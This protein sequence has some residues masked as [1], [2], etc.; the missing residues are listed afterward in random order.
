MLGADAPD[1]D[2]I[3]GTI[4]EP[5][6]GHKMAGRPYLTDNAGTMHDSLTELMAAGYA[7]ILQLDVPGPEDPFVRES[8]PFPNG[9]FHLFQSTE[10]LSETRWFWQY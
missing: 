10:G 3:E 7:Q 9:I 5:A 6:A 8:W 4:Y 1:I 2:I